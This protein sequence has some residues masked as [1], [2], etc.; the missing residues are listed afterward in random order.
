MIMYTSLL[1]PLVVVYNIPHNELQRTLRTVKTTLTVLVAVSYTFWALDKLH[2][3]LP[4]L[5]FVRHNQYDIINYLYIYTDVLN[6]EGRFCGFCL[7][8]GYISLLLVCLLLLN[9]F[10]FRKKSTIMLFAALL[11]TLSLGG[12]VLAVAGYMSQRILR[13]GNYMKKIK[14]FSIIIVALIVITIVALNYNNGDNFFVE[15]IIER[16]MF[17][18]EYGIAGNNRENIVAMQ[19]TDEYFFSNKVWMGIG[20]DAFMRA[21]DDPSFDAASFRLFI[22]NY[23]AIYTI[24]FFIVSIWFLIKSQTKVVFPF[25]LIFWLD[26]IQHGTLFAETLYFMIIMMN[27]YPKDSKLIAKNYAR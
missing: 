16:L 25:F 9:R 23:G 11:C 27:L 24:L 4:S 6:Y 12:Y 19:I 22:I 2:F 10:D 13:Q 3:P 21:I 8:V 15:R 17:D 5:G 20:D 14:V 7:E 18:E 1:L 26:F